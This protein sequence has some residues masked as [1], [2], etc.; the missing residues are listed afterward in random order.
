MK[1]T[2]MVLARSLL[3]SFRSYEIAALIYL[4]ST[5]ILAII[6]RSH[7]DGWSSIILLHTIF[8]SIIILLNKIDSHNSVFL[9][10]LR[11]WYILLFIPFL[12]RELTVLSKSIFPYY[13]EPFL[14]SLE[15]K[16]EL[17]YKKYFSFFEPRFWLTELMS[18]AYWSYFP[19][20]PAIGLRIRNKDGGRGFEFYI[21]KISLTLFICYGLFILMPA[22]GPHHSSFGS[23]PESLNGGIFYHVI[24]YMQNQGSAVGAA[25][26]S[27][28]VTVSWIS[29]F[30]LRKTERCLY[31]ITA[32]LV[33]LLTISAFYLRYHYVLDALAGYVLAIGLERI[34]SKVNH[35]QEK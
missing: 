34:Y 32:S 15:A 6:A 27:A 33:F 2:I 5:A 8:V 13:P 11:D 29:V 4:S 22:R 10:I 35:Q 9:S 14:I 20:I 12:F 25:F 7:I 3:H 28:H 17:L 24:L 26:P 1:Q 31:R 21:L 18:F 19:L 16:L 30:A 23:H